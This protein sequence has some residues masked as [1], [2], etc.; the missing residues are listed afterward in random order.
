MLSHLKNFR[1]FVSYL[2]AVV[3]VLIF[4]SSVFSEKTIDTLLGNGRS[5]Y[6]G[7]DSEDPNDD[8]YAPMS[9]AMDELGNLYLADTLNNKIRMLNTKGVIQ[10]VAGTGKYGNGPN[11]IKALSSD[12]AHPSGVAVETVDKE[13]NKVRIYIADTKNHKIR[14]VNTFGILITIAGRGKPGFSADRVLA[15]SASIALPGEISLD[16]HG[17]VYF[18]DTYNQRIRVIYNP[19]NLPDTGPIAGAPHIKNPKNE[20]IYTV[21]GTGKKGYGGDGTQAISANLNEPWDLCVVNEEIYF[22]DKNNHLIRKIDKT[23]IITTIAGVPMESGY[24]G[25]LLDPIKERLN[26]PFGLCADENYI[27]FADSMNNRIRMIDIKANKISTVAG[28]GEFGFGGDSSPAVNGIFAHPI[29]VCTDKN[30]GFFVVDHV[31]SL[32]RVIKDKS[33]KDRTIIGKSE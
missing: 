24:Q 28:I 5:M 11:R 10:T 26:T 22:T 13:N 12:I 27:Y 32:I 33:L 4:A 1:N 6:F 18:T 25:D 17:N 29:D 19:N 15:T 31:N 20:Y 7:I 9:I 8:F 16:K 30:G 14:M 3:I 2:L 23:G 21:A